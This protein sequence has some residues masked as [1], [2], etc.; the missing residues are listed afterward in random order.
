M[1]QRLANRTE[2][3]RGDAPVYGAVDEAFQVSDLRKRVPKRRPQGR[4]SHEQFHAVQ[5]FLQFLADQEWLVDP[6]PQ[7]ATAHGR[8]RVVQHP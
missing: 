5:S 8:C 3:A 1:A 7:G 6:G 2:L 4:T